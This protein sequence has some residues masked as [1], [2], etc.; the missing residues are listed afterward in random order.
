MAA[1]RIQTALG[2]FDTRS[3][4]M[5]SGWVDSGK[6]WSFWNL[7]GKIWLRKRFCHWTAESPDLFVDDS[8]EIET[9]V[10]NSKI[11]GREQSGIEWRAGGLCGIVLKP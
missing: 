11:S 6:F 3:S 4:W 9:M 7:N 5:W 10:V 1:I 2:G 8:L